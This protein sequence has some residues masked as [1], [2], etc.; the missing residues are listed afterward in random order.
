MERTKS[1]RREGEAC[2]FQREAEEERVGKRL[3]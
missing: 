1:S 2:L 3:N